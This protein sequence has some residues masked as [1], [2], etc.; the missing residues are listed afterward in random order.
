MENDWSIGSVA[1]RFL[2][3]LFR[4][5][6]P[7]FERVPRQAGDIMEVELSHEFCAVVVNGLGS[8]AEFGREF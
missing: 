4:V 3:G 5:D 8:N 6:E 2:E 7:H 1:A